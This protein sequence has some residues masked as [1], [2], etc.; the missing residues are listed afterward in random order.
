M[1]AP[2]GDREGAAARAR[3]TPAS[4]E[5][6]GA[7]GITLDREARKIIVVR[8]K[9]PPPR[10]HPRL[11]RAPPRTLRRARASSPLRAI[12]ESISL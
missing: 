11:P 7:S 9:P 1:P 4:N 10:P 5:P 8:A 2:R 12:A 6:P 3:V